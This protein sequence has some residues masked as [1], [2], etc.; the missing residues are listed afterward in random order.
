MNEPMKTR[1]CKNCGRVLEQDEVDYCPHCK[2]DSD[3]NKKRGITFLGVSFTIGVFSLY[4]WLKKRGGG[5]KE[6]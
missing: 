1:K 2:N 5:D 6:E 4:R 3:K